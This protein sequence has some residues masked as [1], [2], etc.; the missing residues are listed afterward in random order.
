MIYLVLEQVFRI[1]ILRSQNKRHRFMLRTIMKN[2]KSE[3][4]DKINDDWLNHLMICYTKQE[5]FKSLNDVI[6]TRWFH[7]KSHRGF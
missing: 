6:I 2:I 5:K 7:A 4:H 3:L 1:Q